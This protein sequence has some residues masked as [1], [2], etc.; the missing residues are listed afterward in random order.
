MPALW[1]VILRI[2]FVSLFAYPVLAGQQDEFFGGAE[3]QLSLIARGLAARGH[4]VSFVTVDYG[5]PDGVE[6]DSIRVHRAYHPGAGLR[7]VRFLHPRLTSLWA[8]MRRADADVYVQRMGEATT[9]LVAAFCRHA[10]R[11]F[12]FGVASENDCRA[13]LPYC[14]TLHARLLYRYGLRRATTIVAQTGVQQSLLRRNF[15]VDSTIIRSCGADPGFSAALHVGEGHAPPP[16]M[17]W[18][19]RFDW[20]K[21]PEMLL[22]AARQCPDVHFDVIGDSQDAAKAREFS[23]RM[24][25][26]PNVTAHG[27]LPYPRIEPFY[28]QVAAYVL[29]S[30]AEGFPNTFLEAWSHGL[31]VITTYDPDGIVERHGLGLVVQDAVQLRDAIRRLLGNVAAWHRLSTTVREYYHRQ[32]RPQLIAADYEAVLMQAVNRA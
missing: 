13:D 9:G 10:R 15:N 27:W 14:K 30:R 7:V 22:E 3:V 24:R 29:T 6:L 12:V 16:R 8:A 20:N 28:R 31:P 17:L 25:A 32:H 21:R 19:G 26:I 4:A 1:E 11:G 23:V 5:Q 2:C 18:I